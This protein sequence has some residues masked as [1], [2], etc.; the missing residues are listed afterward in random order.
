MRCKCYYTEGGEGL[1]YG[2]KEREPCD[3]G[4]DESRCDYY[5]AKRDRYKDPEQYL[6]QIT[7]IDLRIRS[8]E[9]EFDDAEDE[10]DE[11]YRLELQGR[12]L[13]DLEEAKA[14]K[15]RIRSEIQRV[16]DHKLCTLLMERYVRG[17]CWEQVAEAIGNKSIKHVREG[18]RAQAIAAFLKANP[19]IFKIFTT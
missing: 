16:R 13:Q 18:L 14:L 17:R 10:C 7:D 3:C 2:T 15:L 12:I 8:L 11:E 4:G 1:C 5:P 6:Q 19:E 9:G